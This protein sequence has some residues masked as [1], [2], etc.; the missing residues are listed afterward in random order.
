M[1]TLQEG[2]ESSTVAEGQQGHS[3]CIPAGRDKCDALS[4]H[5]QAGLFTPGETIQY[6]PTAS[7]GSQ[8]EL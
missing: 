3:H 5:S 2:A 6:Q 1:V 7:P 4:K 8:R